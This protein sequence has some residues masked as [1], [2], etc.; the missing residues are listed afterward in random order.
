ME[1]LD[2]KE[3]GNDDIIFM[4]NIHFGKGCG[5]NDNKNDKEDSKRYGKSEKDP[6]EK[7]V[8]ETQKLTQVNIAK[9]SEGIKNTR[10]LYP[11]FRQ[12]QNMF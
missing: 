10:W 12:N 2:L 7:E 3:L 5:R 1:G 4:P 9:L 11:Y 6:E 8:E